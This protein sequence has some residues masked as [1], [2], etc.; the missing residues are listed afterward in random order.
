MTLRV[1]LLTGAALQAALPAVARLRIEV[2][3]DFPYLYDGSEEY[4]RRYLATFAAARGAVMVA[5]LQGDEVVGVSTGVPMAEEMPAFRD[6][7]AAH[8]FDVARVFYCAESVLRPAFRGQGLG[9]R[10]FDLREAHARA[11]GG[12]THVTFCAVVRPDDHP[13]RPPGYRPLDV[14]W[15]KRGYAPVPGLTTTFA[16]KDVDCAEE[17]VKTMQFWMRG[18]E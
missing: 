12:F 2:F 9:H 6:P 13:L 8:G 14:F 7:F 11:L 1:D 16:W 15:R 4:E 10:F 17:T 5:A 18:L 3:R